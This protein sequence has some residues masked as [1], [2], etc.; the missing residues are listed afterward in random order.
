MGR[1]NHAHR[2]TALIG[3]EVDGSYKTGRAKIYPVL[4]N[5][6]L[7]QA[8][9]EY[10]KVTATQPC[11]QVPGFLAIEPEHEYVPVECVQRDYHG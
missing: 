7:S 4:L 6:D 10:L 8:F 1:C 9:H 11:T 5:Q 2:H 3:K